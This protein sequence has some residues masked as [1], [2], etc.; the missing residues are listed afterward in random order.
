LLKP[1]NTAIL[2]FL[3]HCSLPRVAPFVCAGVTLSF[4]HSSD[5]EPHDYEVCCDWSVQDG[6]L[7]ETLLVLKDGLADYT[8]G[9]NWPQ[10]VEELIP[11]EISRLFFFDGEKIRTLAE[12]AGSAEALGAAV[13]APPGRAGAERLIAGAAI[14]QTRRTKQL[15][16]PEQRAAVEELE[17]QLAEL[18][19]RIRDL[20]AELS[21]LENRRQRAVEE[22]RKAEE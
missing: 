17:R 19:G 15:G 13:Q 8:L 22:L 11:L 20:N 21:A 9:R 18:D 16:T 10:L 5:S 2:A 7:R 1:A 3:S 12:D 6:T 4:R 14:V